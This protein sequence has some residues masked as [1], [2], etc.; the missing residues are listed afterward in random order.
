MGRLLVEHFADQG[1][2][3]SFVDINNA[4]ANSVIDGIRVSIGPT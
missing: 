1:S 2:L 3:V 4:A